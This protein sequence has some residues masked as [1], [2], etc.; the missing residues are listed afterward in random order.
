MEKD[1]FLVRLQSVKT[2]IFDVDGVFTDGS[3]LIAEDGRLLRT[4]N[5]RDGYS[6]REAVNKGYE[7]VI[8]T[9]G[10]NESVKIRLE[11]LG[12]KT[13]FLGVHD[14]LSKYKALKAERNWPEG[15]VLYVGD[16]LNDYEVMQAADLAACPSDAAAEI[17]DMADYISPFPGGKGCVRDLVQKVLKLN[18]DWLIV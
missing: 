18:G 10:N 13:I 1:N 16:D 7:I 17:Q 3:L 14:K 9:G 8:I 12:V 6:V 4:M 15:S 2:F 11:G 5:A